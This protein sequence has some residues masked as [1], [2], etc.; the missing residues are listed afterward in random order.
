MTDGTFRASS[1]RYVAS[2]V[3]VGVGVYPEPQRAEE[4]AGCPR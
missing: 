2:N 4:M 3:G 1:E